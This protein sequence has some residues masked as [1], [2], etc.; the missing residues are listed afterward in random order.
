M[1]G[2]VRGLEIAL[3]KMKKGEMASVIVKSPYAY[4]HVGSAELAVPG[5]ADLTYTITLE[6]FEQ[7]KYKHEMSAQDKLAFAEKA[8]ELGTQLFKEGK[9]DQAV[10]KYSQIT[11]YLG[12][13]PDNFSDSEDEE[14]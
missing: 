12:D 9:L 14:I 2:V 4:G 1:D 13:E 6:D 5:G 10:K 11:E 3:L 8:K 7:A